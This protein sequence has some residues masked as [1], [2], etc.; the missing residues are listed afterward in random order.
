MG[1]GESQNGLIFCGVGGGG[2][3]ESFS[4]LSYGV[5]AR[6]SLERLSCLRPKLCDFPR[7]LKPRHFKDLPLENRHAFFNEKFSNRLPFVVFV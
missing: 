4:L 2:K 5:N 3:A 1:G 7:S 6:F